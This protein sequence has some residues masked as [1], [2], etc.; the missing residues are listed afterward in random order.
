MDMAVCREIIYTKQALTAR[1]FT[2]PT[3][4]NKPY[5]LGHIAWLLISV[6]NM[7]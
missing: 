7:L 1:E 5:H 6:D 4:F 3:P 2:K